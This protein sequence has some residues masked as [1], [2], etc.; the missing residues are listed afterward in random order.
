MK[1]PYAKTQIIPHKLN[2]YQCGDTG[3]MIALKKGEN[4]LPY[5]FRCDCD[6]GQKSKV[7]FEFWS[8]RLERHF[9]ALKSH[10]LFFHEPLS[11]GDAHR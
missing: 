8:L 4:S 2:C 6:K 11:E 1:L 3:K 7:C 9:V 10:E 5:A